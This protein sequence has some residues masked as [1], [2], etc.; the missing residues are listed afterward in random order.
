MIRFAGP[1]LNSTG[2]SEFG[3]Y[4]VRAFHEHH[5]PF[6]TKVIDVESSRPDLGQLGSVISSS[7]ND[8][9]T[10]VN[11]INM[12]PELAVKFFK[13]RM[14]NVIFTMFETTRIPAGWVRHC[15]T[16]DAIFVPCEW[17]KEVFVGSGV[18]KPVHVVAPGVFISDFAE[19]GISNHLNIQP[20]PQFSFYS[21]FQWSERKNPIGLLRA[22]FSEFT[23]CSDVALILKTYGAN[24]SAAERQRVRSLIQ[25]V[26]KQMNLSHF[27][28]IA[29]IPDMLS[30]KQ[31]QD[32]HKQGDC[33]VLPHRAEGFGMPHME[34]MAWGRP[35]ITTGFSGNMDFMS[36]DVA[37]LLNFQ[38]TPVANMSWI[39][40]YEG[41]MMWAEPDLGQLR[42]HMRFAY[43]H[44]VEIKEMGLKGREH[45]SR[46]LD[47]DVR[48]DTLNTIIK[49]L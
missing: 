44:P 5:I 29:L 28:K 41:N 19:T 7:Q 16:A 6:C 35:V 9:G 45:V 26:K 1:L 21:V 25:D 14:P 27:P 20:Q 11:I 49:G 2:Y 12:T 22:Y 47:W 24:F 37:L 36:P 39:K 15:N 43:E 40:W 10:T 31:M 46:V 18:K 48:L 33:F 3:R 23:G 42:Q 17:N 30:T 8:S 38:F 13:P 4:F 34:A 32:L